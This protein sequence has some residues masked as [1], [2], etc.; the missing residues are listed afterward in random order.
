MKTLFLFQVAASLLKLSPDESDDSIQIIQVKTITVHE[1]FDMFKMSNNI[2]VLELTDSFDTSVD[3]V[4]TIA[5]PDSAHGEG[6]GCDV[7]G[8]GSLNEW[9]DFPGQLQAVEVTITKQDE[10]QGL[11]GSD[12]DDT[13]LCA[14]DDGKGP[15]LGDAGGPLACDDGKLLTGIVSWSYGCGQPGQPGVYTDVFQ[16]KDWIE[17]KTP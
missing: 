16:F 11:Y 10:C 14:G 1:N 9:G 15:C 17:S 3:T 2:A 13:M 12:V 6:D 7:S 5:V 4:G 8:W